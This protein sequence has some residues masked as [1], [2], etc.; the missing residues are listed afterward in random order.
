MKPD[1]VYKQ[2]HNAMLDW[3]R[4]SKKGDPIPSENELRKRFGVSRSTIERLEDYFE[5]ESN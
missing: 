2:A 1:T 3:L 5:Q 4:D